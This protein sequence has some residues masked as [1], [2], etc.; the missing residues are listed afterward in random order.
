MLIV[1]TSLEVFSAFRFVVRA[2]LQQLPIA[3]VN[4]GET[5]AER[6]KLRSIVYKSDASCDKLLER[7]QQR[8]F[9]E[10]FAY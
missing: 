6:E 1:G 4:F 3:I 9:N 7:V 8:L 5:R 10:G 2:N